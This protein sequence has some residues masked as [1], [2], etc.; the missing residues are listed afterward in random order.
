[1]PELISFFRMRLFPANIDEIR[2][3]LERI[4]QITAESKCFEQIGLRYFPDFSIFR[5]Q[6]P[7]LSAVVCLFFPDFYSGIRTTDSG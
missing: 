7:N 4:H 1:M 2:L 5:L 3:R 6:A